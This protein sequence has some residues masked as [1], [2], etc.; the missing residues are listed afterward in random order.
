[1]EPHGLCPHLTPARATTDLCSSECYRECVCLPS[2]ACL[3][4]PALPAVGHGSLRIIGYAPVGR[5]LDHTHAWT[6]MLFVGTTTGYR[7]LLFAPAQRCRLHAYS[8][9]LSRAGAHGHRP[10]RRAASTPV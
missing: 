6:H 2:S 4:L 3:P 8:N 7:S 10:A 5:L 9:C 1:M